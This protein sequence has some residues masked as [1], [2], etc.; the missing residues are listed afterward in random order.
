MQTGDTSPVLTHHARQQAQSRG[1][2]VHIVEAIY[3]NADRGA[4]VG[5]G[6]RSLMISRKRINRLSETLSPA[7]R[8]RMDGVV[9]VV[10]H[11]SEV[12]VTVL[13]SHGPKSQRYRRQWYGHP[14]RRTRRRPHWHSGQ[15]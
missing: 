11:A 4:F 15:S 6:C 10:D 2:P 13:H 12:V 7:D 14:H 1:I 5:S 9:L 3:S 8:E